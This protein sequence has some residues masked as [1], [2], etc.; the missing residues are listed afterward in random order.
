[1]TNLL[2]DKKLLVLGGTRLSCEIVRKAKEM[3]MI[4]FV[5]DYLEDS[6]A[7]KIADKSF[8]VSTTDI[9]G[10]TDLIRSERIDGILTGF[11]DS[12][13]P[14]FQQICARSGLPCYATREQIEIATDKA[15]FKEL[16]RKFDVPVVKEYSINPADPG[17]SIED[18]DYPV[19]LKP[20]DNSGGRG[21]FICNDSL[22]FASSYSKAL[23]FSKSGKVIIEKYMPRKE[24][25]IFY[26]IKDGDISLSSVADRHLI[27]TRNGKIALPV[28][29]IFPSCHQDKYLSSLNS[30]VVRMFKSLGV[31]NGMIF[32]QSFVEEEGF[33]FYEMGFRLTGS[34]EYHVLSRMGCPNILEQ[35][36]SFSVTG[37]MRYGTTVNPGLKSDKIGCNITFLA[38]PGKIARIEGIEMLNKLPE[39]V[40]VVLAYDEN[41]T[42]PESATGTLKQV[43]AR[44]F[45]V[46]GSLRQ[47]K[48][49]MDKIHQTFNVLSDNGE[50]MLLPVFN[51]EELL[52]SPYTV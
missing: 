6:P 41:E 32:I 21:I 15:R 31:R 7:K 51:T 19:I 27:A 43:V 9:E 36:I 8:M 44:I 50:S 46:S 3:G 14:Y 12:L 4:V 39:V 22:E 29:Y 48:D 47:V 2:K 26:T 20:V 25:S 18:L 5:T 40:E 45:V 23:T 11:I 13:L 52:T 28:A 37:D 33:T 24:V 38:K 49:V 30:K 34:L 16:C 42:I 35:M 17:N 10:V 1:M